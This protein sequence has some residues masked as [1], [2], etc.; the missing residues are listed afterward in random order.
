MAPDPFLGVVLHAIGGLAAASFYVPYR[1]VRGW[2]WET[3]WLVGG[4]FSWIIVPWI[5]VLLTAPNTL[6]ILREAPLSSIEWAFVFGLLWGVG[7]LTFGLSMRY[8]G[9]ALGYAVALGFCAAFGTL[10]PPL[11]KGEF[12]AL[13]T[14]SSGITILAGVAICLFGIAVSGAAGRSREK[15][16][17]EEEKRSVITE[18]NFPKGI[19]VAVFA[20]I[21]SASMSYGIQAGKP[22]AAIAIKYGTASLFQNTP[23]FV[24]IL[25]GG[26]LTNF[27]WCV[28]LAFRNKTGGDYI[29]RSNP[30][31]LNYL[32]CAIAG[33]TWYAQFMF[34]G[35]GTTKMGHYD[36]S[37][38][39]L[40]MSA[41]IIFS[42]L[43]GIALKEWRGTKRHTHWLI[44]AGLAILIFSTIV[45]G[46]GN[47]LE[48]QRISASTVLQS[49]G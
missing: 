26:F 36:F 15:D 20:G 49:H 9:I 22:I 46:Y 5:L 7:G 32:L 17:P 28:Y 38:W 19:M 31:L 6:F 13:L 30:V 43:W 24:V 34:Y 37:S 35:M 18:L 25:T 4:F 44:A 16:M 23:V 8:L 41:I 1:K 11:F 42:T 39:T 29:S 47:Y 48:A 45:V 3:Y 14:T 33:A 27:I 2:A 12:G 10:M 21:L 40:H